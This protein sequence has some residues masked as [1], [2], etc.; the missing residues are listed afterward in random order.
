MDRRYQEITDLSRSVISTARKHS[1]PHSVQHSHGAGLGAGAEEAVPS[2]LVPV[3]VVVLVVV[4]DV[5]PFTGVCAGAAL[6]LYSV[7]CAPLQQGLGGGPA[8]PLLLPRLEEVAPLL[9]ACDD[10]PLV[11]PLLLGEGLAPRKRE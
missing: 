5:V 3:H 9:C 7:S 10:P 2:A 4:V 8:G 11:L 6:H 1:G